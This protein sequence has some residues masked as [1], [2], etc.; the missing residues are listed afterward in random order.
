MLNINKL[1]DA[2]VYYKFNT[3][4][5]SYFI[6]RKCFFSD[7]V[8]RFYKAESK[9][10]GKS[11]RD[12]SLLSGGLEAWKLV[13]LLVHLTFSLGSDGR[14]LPA[15]SAFMEARGV[16][17][18]TITN[19]SDVIS[20]ACVT[21]IEMHKALDA[22]SMRYEDH[23]RVLYLISVAKYHHIRL[24]VLKKVCWLLRLKEPTD[25]AVIKQLFAKG[26]SGNKHHYM[27]HLLQA[28]LELGCNLIAVDTEMSE[29]SHKPFVKEPFDHS[30]KRLS[31][32]LPEMLTYVLKLKLIDY[33]TEFL[34]N[35]NDG[36][37]AVPIASPLPHQV[38]IEYAI[39]DS[40]R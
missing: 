10:G 3:S 30:S 17:S 37:G 4:S 22:K 26:V 23:H 32:R 39:D 40:Y 15:T 38:A 25:R 20:S 1:Y 8:S 19:I 2:A 35:L 5:L 16:H 36:D 28:K 13:P 12:T 24:Q 9:K 21:C 34:K 14:V 11:S 31:S 29:Q 7:G 33:L 6:C 18:S 27:F